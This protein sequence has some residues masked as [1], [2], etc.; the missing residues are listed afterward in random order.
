[1]APPARSRKAGSRRID[2]ALDALRPMGF[3]DKVVRRTVTNLLK[4]YGGDNGWRFIEDGYYQ[5]LID[6]IVDEQAN[7]EK[8]G[9]S[10]KGAKDKEEEDKCQVETHSP[11]P[12]DVLSSPLKERCSENDPFS[13]E[14]RS[15]ITQ[16]PRKKNDQPTQALKPCSLRPENS[17]GTPQSSAASDTCTSK[18]RRSPCYGWISS[19]DE[20]D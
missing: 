7:T 5:L 8:E 11:P 16:F 9:C 12:A 4:V 10:Q 15:A 2:A 17:E 14:R 19:D 1:M 13:P 3:N 20:G 18:L 6:S